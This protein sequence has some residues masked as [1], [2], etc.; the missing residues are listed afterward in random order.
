MI[1]EEH[2][3]TVSVLLRETFYEAQLTLKMNRKQLA[4]DVRSV[5]TTLICFMSNGVKIT[6]AGHINALFLR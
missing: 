1:C 2:L 6:R 3:M 4:W 5:Q